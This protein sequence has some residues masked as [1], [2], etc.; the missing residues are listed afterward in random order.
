LRELLQ[1]MLVG[2]LAS[3]SETDGARRDRTAERDEISHLVE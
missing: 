3:V 1:R 2:L